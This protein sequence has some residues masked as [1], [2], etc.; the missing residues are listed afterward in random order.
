MLE[1]FR[2]NWVGLRTL[3][4]ERPSRADST[5]LLNGKQHPAGGPR[6]RVDLSLVSF[7][8]IYVVKYICDLPFA[9]M[10]FL[11]RRGAPRSHRALVHKFNSPAV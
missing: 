4:T 9:C 3:D 5:I 7:A 1:Y 6:T 2:L 8:D 11:L 10:Q